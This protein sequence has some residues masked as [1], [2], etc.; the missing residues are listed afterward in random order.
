MDFSSEFSVL[1]IWGLNLM[2]DLE[3]G[4]QFMGYDNLFHY[5]LQM[6]VRNNMSLFSLITMPR[7]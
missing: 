6:H 3:S 1:M 5:F 7:N 4:M 2:I